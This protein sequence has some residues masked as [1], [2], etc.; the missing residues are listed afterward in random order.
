[1]SLW[2]KVPFSLD[3][4]DDDGDDAAAAAAAAAADDDDDSTEMYLQGQPINF[5]TNKTTYVSPTIWQASRELTGSVVIW[6][7][8]ILK[9]LILTCLCL[10]LS[11]I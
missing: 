11:V 2:M 7:T 9:V 10:M 5:L 6:K 8:T 3:D 1:M 4:D